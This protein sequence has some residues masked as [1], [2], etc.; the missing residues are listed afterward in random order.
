MTGWKE[1]RPPLPLL[2]LDCF[3]W[4]FDDLSTSLMGIKQALR[5]EQSF[6]SRVTLVGTG[7]SVNALRMD[8]AWTK[9]PDG[10]G[11]TPL[12]SEGSLAPGLANFKPGKG[13]GE[14]TAKPPKPTQRNRPGE[15]T[16]ARVRQGREM[17]ANKEEEPQKGEGAQVSTRSSSIPQG[18][19]APP[20]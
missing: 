5:W 4:L 11:I 8:P 9:S 13:N 15:P 17:G 1:L 16:K 10:H 14:Q 19:V 20:Q 18:T 6:Q 7:P 12:A 3:N 2:P